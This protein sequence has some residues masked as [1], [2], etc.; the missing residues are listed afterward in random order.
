MPVP[1]RAPRRTPDPM[2]LS[3][4]AKTLG[5]AERMVLRVNQKSLGPCVRASFIH[6]RRKQ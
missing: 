4:Q 2:D 3:A 6:Q 1:I 5:A